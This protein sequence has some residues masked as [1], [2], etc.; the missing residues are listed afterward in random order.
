MINT[1]K[2]IITYMLKEFTWS[3]LVFFGIFFSLIL[4]TGYVEELIFF[5]EKNLSENLFVKC[6]ILT[7]AKSPSFIIEFLPFIVL[8]AAVFFYVKFLSKNEIIPINLSGISNRLI[9]IIPASYAFFLGIFFIIVITPISSQLINF[10]ENSKSKFSDN[11]NLI[12]VSETGLW[13]KDRVNGVNLIIRADKI[14][15][16]DFSK[17][18]NVSIY[19]F[20]KDDDLIKRLESQSALIENKLWIL[21]GV[22]EIMKDKTNS[23]E[24]TELLTN[25][26]FKKLMNYFSNSHSFSIWNINKELN[27]IRNIGYYGQEL[28]ISFNKFLSLPFLLFCMTIIA[29]LFTIDLGYR[30]N[31]FV[32]VFLG[33]LSSIAVHF[34][35]DLSISLGKT[36]KIPL[37]FSIWIPILILSIICIYALASKNE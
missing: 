33:I 31:T 5:K 34:L 28:I 22:K 35:G 12:F 18:S 3:L 4:L 20:D 29:T 7:L 13:L 32:Y 15:N 19:Q 36:G 25:I 1:P 24:K 10:Y 8:F 6:L 17:L 37:I 2:M 14:P 27:N 21:K 16:Q 26:N 11:Q 23:Y 30:F 9:T